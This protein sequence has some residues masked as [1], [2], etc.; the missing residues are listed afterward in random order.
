MVSPSSV[1]RADCDYRQIWQRVM[2]ELPP[3]PPPQSLDLTM[4]TS[5]LLQSPSLTQSPTPSTISKFEHRPSATGAFFSRVAAG[6]SRTS[7]VGDKARPIVSS[8]MLSASSSVNTVG[9]RRSIVG[10]GSVSSRRP[11]VELRSGTDVCDVDLV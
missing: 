6:I 5:P 8:P 3:L 1:R 4:P 7:S 9:D 10:L 2:R 11:P